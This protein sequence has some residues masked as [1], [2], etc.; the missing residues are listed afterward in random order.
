[1]SDLLPAMW[2]KALL[3]ETLDAEDR[4][5]RSLW[6]TAPANVR[7]FI[8]A[9]LAAAP[10]QAAPPGCSLPLTEALAREVCKI[11]GRDPDE[12]IGN[13]YGVQWPLHEEVYHRLDALVAPTTAART[14]RCDKSGGSACG[15]AA[16]VPN[17]ACHCGLAAV[18][19]LP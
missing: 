13:G 17:C 11:A 3:V 2:L 6:E 1:M 4:S 9:S 8:K 14:K 5:A 16:L 10:A 19:P 18:P 15:V 7:E 12:N